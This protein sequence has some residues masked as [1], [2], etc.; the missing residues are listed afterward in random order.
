M[1]WQPA[2]RAWS[3]VMPLMVPRVPT[4]M[5]AG[6]SKV[7]WGVVILLT[8]APALV[9]RRFNVIIPPEFQLVSTLFV[10]LSLFLGSGFG[11]YYKFWWW[12]LVLHSGSG[13]LLGIVGFIVLFF[14]NQTDGLPAG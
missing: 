7:P 5:K 10:F 1:H 14:M 2:A 12:D 11:F 4:A 3:G 9:W 8:L 13:F 6:V